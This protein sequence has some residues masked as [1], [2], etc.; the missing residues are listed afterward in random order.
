M[1]SQQQSSAVNW[2]A[3]SATLLILSVALMLVPTQG[4]QALLNNLQSVPTPKRKVSLGSAPPKDVKIVGIR[5]V[6]ESDWYNNVEVEIQNEGQADIWFLQ[7]RVGMPEYKREKTTPVF[8][9]DFGKDSPTSGGVNRPNKPVIRPGERYTFRIPPEQVKNFAKGYSTDQVTVPP[10][11]WIRFELYK[12]YFTD[13]TNFIGGERVLIAPDGSVT[14]VRTSELR[15]GSD[16]LIPRNS[17]TRLASLISPSSFFLQARILG[18]SRKRH[19][20]ARVPRETPIAR[21]IA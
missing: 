18:L 9:V 11:G 21:I 3:L 5:N 12:I 19:S 15:R 20:G 8:V 2:P 1:R 16:R 17:F 13:G 10:V 6:D 7:L 14:P 4:S